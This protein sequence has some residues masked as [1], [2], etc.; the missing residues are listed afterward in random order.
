M[1]FSLPL[2]LAPALVAAH[3]AVTSYII[4][5]T[6]YPG[7]QGFSPQPNA[8]IIQRQVSSL[9]C[10]TNACPIYSLGLYQTT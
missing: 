9:F 1:L 3:G 8:Q 7:Y 5:G 2:V 6:T 10:L 4:S